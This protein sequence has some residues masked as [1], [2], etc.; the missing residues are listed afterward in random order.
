ME[1]LLTECGKKRLCISVW[2]DPFVVS[3][4]FL[5]T[6]LWP[7]PP[8][9]TAS[10]DRLVGC[11]STIVMLFLETMVKHFGAVRIEVWVWTH[12][13]V[14]LLLVFQAFWRSCP[15]WRWTWT[16][17]WC[18]RLTLAGETE[19]FNWQGLIWSVGLLASSILLVSVSGLCFR[20]RGLLWSWS[21]AR[22]FFVNSHVS[23]RWNDG[24][25]TALLL[26]VG[27][28]MIIIMRLRSIS[29]SVFLKSVE[30]AAWLQACCLWSLLC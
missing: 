7:T 25:A 29:I 4:Y 22:Y 17:W 27:V 3:N 18:L 24:H 23:C 20:D 16:A 1:V 2:P 8:W 28:I 30:S 5:P 26:T 10:L 14:A 6:H 12:D 11:P 19:S 9:C 13:D 21:I 15:F